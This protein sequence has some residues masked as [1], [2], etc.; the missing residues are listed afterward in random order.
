MVFLTDAD[1]STGNG[2]YSTRLIRFVAK[3]LPSE[4]TRVLTLCLLV[5]LYAAL[6]F[7]RFNR[8]D[9]GCLVCQAQ[10]RGFTVEAACTNS[11]ERSKPVERANNENLPQK[12]PDAKQTLSDNLQ[13]CF[14]SYRALLPYMWPSKSRYLQLVAYVCFALLGLQR[15]VNILIPSQTEAM[16][17]RLLDVSNNSSQDILRCIIYIWLQ[18]EK[19]LLKSLHSI[20]W[21]RVRRHCSIQLSIAAFEHVHNL[22][23][24]FH[25]GK[26]NEELLSAMRDGEAITVF[27]ELVTFQIIPTLVD[28]GIAMGCFWILFDGY[29]SLMLDVLYVGYISLTAHLAKGERKVQRRTVVAYRE[30]SSTK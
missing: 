22:I 28:F 6:Y 20:L 9:T 29:T 4:V 13:K 3:V 26:Q 18:D 1:L 27:L 24:D 19:G 23:L 21:D 12:N 2:T 30:E 25:L 15:I 16:F 10:S 5:I 7:S 11:H 14:R 8:T 17:A